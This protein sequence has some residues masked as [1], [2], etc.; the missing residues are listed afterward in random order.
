MK[1]AAIVTAM[2]LLGILMLFSGS[3]AGFESGGLIEG[4]VAMDAPN[5]SGQGVI[6]KWKPLDKSH[7]SSSIRSTGAPVLTACSISTIWTWT[8]CWE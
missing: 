1:K 6:L 7:R 4:L 5:D 8:P 3:G 2:A